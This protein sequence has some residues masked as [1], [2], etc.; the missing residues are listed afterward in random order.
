[1][2]ILNCFTFIPTYTYWQQYPLI[3]KI[4]KCIGKNIYHKEFIVIII[5]FI[6][7]SKLVRV[8]ILPVLFRFNFRFKKKLPIFDKFYIK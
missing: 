5:S 2:P 7:F 1:M 6:W 3:R 4:K 8:S